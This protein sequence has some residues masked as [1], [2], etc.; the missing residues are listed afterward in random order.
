M[1]GRRFTDA[2]VDSVVEDPAE[3]VIT[4]LTHIIIGEI[5]KAFLLLFKEQQ[6]LSKCSILIIQTA[7][8]F[9]T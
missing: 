8:L 3:H 6:V 7:Q 5:N 2:S 4:Q 9:L 1:V